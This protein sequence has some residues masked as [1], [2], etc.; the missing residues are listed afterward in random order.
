[1]SSNARSTHAPPGALALILIGSKMNSPIADANDAQ[2]PWAAP[3]EQI[4]ASNAKTAILMKN[5][6]WERQATSVESTVVVATITN[7]SVVS[8][9]DAT[10]RSLAVNWTAEL[11]T[12]LRNFENCPLARMNL[13]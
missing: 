9:R 11:T 1:M 7:G 2:P 5:R 13:S 8:I 6:V 3:R 4:P 12:K 10:R